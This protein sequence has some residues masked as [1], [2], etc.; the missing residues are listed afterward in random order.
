MATLTDNKKVLLIAITGGLLTAGSFL[1][2]LWARSRIEDEKT[3]IVDLD[4]K[5]ATAEG[6]KA[7]I[8]QDE[9]DVI[10]LRENVTEYV[11]ILPEDSDLTDFVR[12]VNSFAQSSGVQLKS[13]T[14][15]AKPRGKRS[16]FSR[17]TYKIAFTGSL[18]Q[19]L[20]F[21]NSFES[22]KRFVRVNAF[23]L[24]AGRPS[25]S[26][27]IVEEVI[28]T[29]NLTVETYVY[30]HRAGGKGTVKIVNY[31]PKRDRLR[32]E[33]YRSRAKIRVDKY[34]F[35]GSRARRDIYVDPRVTNESE[36]P[37]PGIPLKDQVKM[38][39][40]LSRRVKSLTDRFKQ[41]NETSVLLVK[42]EGIREVTRGIKELEL[43]LEKLNE[44]AYITYL[45]YRLRLQ[46]EVVEPV[47]VLKRKVSSGNE[48]TGPIGLSKRDLEGV[49]RFMVDALIDGRI[50]DAID[51]YELIEAKLIFP[52]NDERIDTAANV[53]DLYRKAKIARDFSRR[54]LKITG[55]ILLDNSIS[56]AIING[57]TYQ[58]G[59]AVDEDLFLKEIKPESIEFLFKGIVIAKKR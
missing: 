7:R 15:G 13:V 21:M 41:A 32:E 11:K 56:T 1:G 52:K 6:K 20:K 17:H 8:P 36:A 24:S 9:R 26:S 14:P 49:R 34:N 5:I 30:N 10:I 29:L 45:P 59:D 37:G 3:K 47:E 16:A 42:Y 53:R 25:D 58:E 35:R 4:Q 54:A 40:K 27:G 46:H 44:T 48:Q 55:V 43:R 12:T 38:V 31:A 22:F 57:K 2:V 28:H 51:R 18:W 33:I 39:E 50:E 19:F 23:N